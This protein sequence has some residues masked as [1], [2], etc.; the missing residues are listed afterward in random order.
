MTSP[1]HLKLVRPYDSVDDFLE[2]E[3]WSIQPKGMLLLEEPEAASGALVRFEV[4]LRTGER[5]IRAEGT[6]V[7]HAAAREDRPA[8]LKVRFKRLDARSKALID[9]AGAAQALPRPPTEPPRP[10][11]VSLPDADGDSSPSAVEI[12]GES[13]P[14]ASDAPDEVREPG[15]DSGVRRVTATA[16]DPPRN[17]D[18]LLARL[19]DRYRDPARVVEAPALDRDDAD[20]G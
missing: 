11:M 1:L 12:L 17:R 18:E 7:G 19:R 20:T 10:P 15:E 8:G 9:R 6:V 5:L 16:A 4:Q 2:A 3:G 14:T 13:S